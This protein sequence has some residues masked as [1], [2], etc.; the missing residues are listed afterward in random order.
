MARLILPAKK[1]PNAFATVM[2]WADEARRM[3]VRTNAETPTKQELRWIL[4]RRVLAFA[5]PNI[6]FL[7][8]PDRCHAADDHGW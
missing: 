8:R 5:G 3:E 1:C 7:M 2:R 4:V 6:C